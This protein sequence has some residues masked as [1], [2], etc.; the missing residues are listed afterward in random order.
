V[1]NSDTAAATGDHG[2]GW[3]G[4][5]WHGPFGDDEGD[6]LRAAQARACGVG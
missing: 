4:P 1:I 6:A 3:D 2:P 5:G